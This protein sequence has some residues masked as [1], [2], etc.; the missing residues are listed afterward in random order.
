VDSAE[1]EYCPEVVHPLEIDGRRIE[2][3][4]DAY[5]FGSN[6]VLINERHVLINMVLVKKT[7]MN[8]VVI[9]I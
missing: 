3:T 4:V 2:T 5:A 7:C 9:S 6:F 8:N 1:I